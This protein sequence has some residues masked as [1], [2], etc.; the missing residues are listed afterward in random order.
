MYAT[1]EP[2]P[3][4]IPVKARIAIGI[5]DGR[6]I[7]PGDEVFMSRPQAEEAIAQGTVEYSGIEKTMRDLKAA[8]GRRVTGKLS[9]AAKEA[10]RAAGLGTD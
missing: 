8:G 3:G 5:P 6:A 2:L 4:R 9:R 10:A 1:F 7:C